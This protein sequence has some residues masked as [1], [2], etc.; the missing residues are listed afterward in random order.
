MDI[1]RSREVKLIH[2]KDKQF[3]LLT[4]EEPPELTPPKKRPTVYIDLLAKNKP[5]RILVDSSMVTQVKATGF[6]CIVNYVCRFIKGFAVQKIALASPQT[7]QEHL[8][9]KLL[10]K[11][12]ECNATTLF[13]EL[14][15]ANNW[16]FSS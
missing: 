5:A 9:L 16:V 12:S 10:I 3:L 8:S 4:F 13:K 15:K 1:I 11:L 14:G 7:L 2:F 6:S